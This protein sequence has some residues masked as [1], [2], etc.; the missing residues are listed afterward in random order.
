MR[1]FGAAGAERRACAGRRMSP[2]SSGATAARSDGM[3]SIAEDRPPEARATASAALP[4]VV[5]T[6]DWGGAPDADQRAFARE[7]L[8]SGQILFFPHLPFDT[9]ERERELFDPAIVKS[10]KKKSAKGRP[11]IVYF[12]DKDK[13]LKA[14][15][16]DE[17]R[18]VL[19]AMVV[20][21]G[22]WARRVVLDNFPEYEPHLEWGPTSFRPNSRALQRVHVDAFFVL[23]TQGRRV[24]RIFTNVNPAG[25]P[26]C[27]DVSETFET[28]AP[29][30]A[31]RL[32]S[33]TLAGRAAR[34]A[35]AMAHVTIGRQTP[36]DYAMWQMRNFAKE[37]AEF[38]GIRKPETVAFPAGSTWMCYTDAVFHAG[39]SG[40]HAFEQTFMIEPE[41]M[42]A[43]DRS[44]LRILEGLTGRRLC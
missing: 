3:V 4:D 35:M 38:V 27:W 36:Y 21:Y 1:D 6:A 42:Y 29:R 14:G 32:K 5:R 15:V 41:G 20:R 34:R 2:P 12:P 7:V 10:I 9:T 23:P 26:R 11:R 24:L 31:H 39:R 33:D 18:A 17:A 22:Q 30:H 43:P 16:E 37:D 44:P 25:V 13:L 8:E 28:F 19:R 40:Q